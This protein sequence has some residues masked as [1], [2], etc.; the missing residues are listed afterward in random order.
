[1]VKLT[2]FP[3]SQRI[4]RVEVAIWTAGFDNLVNTVLRFSCEPT[5]RYYIRAAQDME[6]NLR[7]SL[8]GQTDTCSRISRAMQSGLLM[9][10][11]KLY[12]DQVQDSKMLQKEYGT[13]EDLAYCYYCRRALNAALFLRQS[14]TTEGVSEERK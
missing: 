8:D 5:I 4:S 2:L 11:K 6:S 10:W 12:G 9:L 3:S 7:T 14:M 1:M 13:A